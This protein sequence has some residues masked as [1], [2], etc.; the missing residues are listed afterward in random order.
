MS[1]I[2][3]F[4]NDEEFS[5]FNP[6]NETY[7]LIGNPVGH[8]L[9]DVLHKKIFEIKKEDKSY[10]L[11]EPSDFEK[12]VLNLKSKCKGFNVTVP[13]KS[14]IIPYLDVIDGIAKDIGA[15]NTVIVKD[16]KL[17]G[18]NSDYYGFLRCLKEDKINLKGAKALVLGYGGVARMIAY[19]SCKNG[20]LTEIYGRNKE[21]AD[22]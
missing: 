15:V 17:I 14:Q 19:A 12:T 10:I 2:K 20:A 1:D 13:F 21:K 3:N 11:I 16:D 18:Y 9:S 8:S 22:E 6:Y 4:L 7:A 5:K